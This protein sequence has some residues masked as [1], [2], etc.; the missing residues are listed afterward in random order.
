MRSAV[1][2]G[3]ADAGSSSAAS[4]A[5]GSSREGPRVRE[6]IAVPVAAGAPVDHHALAEAGGAVGPGVGDGR[7][8]H[9][10][11]AQ[12]VRLARQRAVIDD[13]LDDV[14]AAEIH[15]ER[16]PYCPRIVEGR[17]ASLRALLDC[18]GVGERVAIGVVAR[19]AV[20]H[21]ALAGSDCPVLAGVRA[22][23]RIDRAD[24]HGVG[25]A[26]REPV[27]DG[28][29]H[30]VRPGN[31]RDQRGGDLRGAREGGGAAFRPGN[32]FPGERELIA[33]RVVASRGIQFRRLAD[34]AP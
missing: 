31:V 23:A 28:E 12:P 26:H 5:G 1:N 2:D 34:A 6:R 18:P 21:D 33:V 32:Q 13:Q 3:A 14:C 9:A 16:R 11:Q 10:V 24:G 20:E 29:R 19:T 27:A 25:R 7:R 4:A 17:R 22:G 8:V 30:R 15:E